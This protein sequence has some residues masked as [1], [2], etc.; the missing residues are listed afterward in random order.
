LDF[1]LDLGQAKVEALEAI[2]EWRPEENPDPKQMIQRLR[3]S[4]TLGWSLPALNTMTITDLE[5]T[6]NLGVL[7]DIKIREAV[8]EYY[9][10]QK[11]VRE[12]LDRRMTHYPRRIYQIV[13]SEILHA[14]RG[15]TVGT[16]E[17]EES[18]AKAS[19]TTQIDSAPFIQALLRISQEIH[20][21]DF[22]R[23]L[24]AE[25]NYARVVVDLLQALRVQTAKLL[26]KL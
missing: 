16:R 13:P 22:Q 21:E 18:L 19:A 14:W 5:S 12:R 1:T 8:L 6:G 23:D 10:E 20:T 9:R 24:R 15:T 26:E 25:S 3:Q 4:I 2:S 11:S 17:A 7:H